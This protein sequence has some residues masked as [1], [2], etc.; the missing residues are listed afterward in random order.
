MLSSTSF[1]GLLASV[2]LAIGLVAALL[3]IVVRRA[4]GSK[5]GMRRYWQ[6]G[7]KGNQGNLIEEEGL[8]NRTDTSDEED[9]SF[10]LIN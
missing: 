8:V 1:G 6:V 4:G 7:E 5:V 2:G 10:D 9:S 3:C